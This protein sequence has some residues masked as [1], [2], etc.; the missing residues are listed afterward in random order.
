MFR[1]SKNFLLICAVLVFSAAIVFAEDAIT[2]T[3]Y[4]P[5][6]YGVYNQLG[7]NR[8]AVGDTD[9]INGLDAADQPN[10]DGDIRLK[11]QAGNPTAWPA[12]TIGQFAYSSTNDSLYHY[13][14]SAWV[15]SG[16]G[17]GCYVDYGLASGLP[18]GSACTVSGFTVKGSAGNWGN[19]YIWFG[20]PTG[21]A[22]FRPPGGGCG[23]WPSSNNGD[24][25]VCCQ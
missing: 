20:N 6:P 7:T 5:S 21:L 2:I 12:G 13:N 4:Y 3:T 14:G 10:R 23:G 15:A 8:L 19:C 17:G 24:A 11:A 25:Y 9:G 22:H 1:L 18:N 16:G